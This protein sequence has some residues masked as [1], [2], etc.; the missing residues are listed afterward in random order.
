M[1]HLYTGEG[2]GK[3]TAAV[4][5]AVRHLGS[6]GTLAFVQFLKSSP[7][8]EIAVLESL[9]RATVLRNR[10]QHGFAIHMSDEQK[11]RVTAAHNENLSKAQEMVRHGSISMLVLD[12]LCAAYALQLIDRDAVDALIESAKEADIELVI[13]GRDPAPGFVDAADYITE[14]RPLRHPYEKGVPARRG[15]EY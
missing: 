12:E 8:G 5:L 14:M 15:V 2:K 13:T 3:T 4:G 6:G 1:I 7:S 9:P 11:R 10:E